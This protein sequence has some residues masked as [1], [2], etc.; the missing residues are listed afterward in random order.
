[1]LRSLF[2]DLRAKGV[3]LTIITKG[4]VGAVAKLLKEEGL[5]ENF[6]IVVGFIGKFYG[7]TEYDTSCE[8]SSLEGGTENELQVTKADFVQMALQRE[9]LSLRQAVLVEDDPAEIA[10]VRQP[11]ICRAVFVRKRMGMM[12]A[13]MDRLRYLSSP[14]SQAGVLISEDKRIPLHLP[15]TQA[16]QLFPARLRT[17]MCPAGHKLQVFTTQ[18]HGWRCDNCNKVLP[19]G[20]KL[21]GCRQCEYDAC[22]KCMDDVKEGKLGIMNWRAGVFFLFLAVLFSI[23]FKMLEGFR[24]SIRHMAD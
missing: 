2:A 22:S 13:E 14:P 1:M 18:Q 5:L 12:S 16:P 3:V 7:E 23:A 9:G 4:Y 8:A 24:A 21:H 19:K 15:S 10:S 6:D 11:P 17:L 20:C